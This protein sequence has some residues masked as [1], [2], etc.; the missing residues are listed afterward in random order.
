MA[1]LPVLI[2]AHVDA[3]TS[4][5]DAR[6]LGIHAVQIFIGDPQGWKKPV[7][8]YDGGPAALREA[9]Q[10]ARITAYVHAP[11]VINVASTNNRIRI[12]S[13]KLL[14]QTLHAAAEIGAAGVIVHGGHVTAEDDPGQG[15]ENWFKAVG[16]AE[17]EVPMLVENTAGGSHAMARTLPQLEQLWEAISAAENGERVGFCLD[18][19]HAFAAGL[20]LAT[21]VDDVRAA[22]GRIDLLHL[23][24]SRGDAGSGQDRHAG[25]GQGQIDPEQIVQVI[26]AAG[27]PVILETPGGTEERTADIAWLRDRLRPR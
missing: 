22:T 7:V 12:P 26:R 27:V 15:Y 20:D 3:S 5:D 19:C 1:D 4:V 24:D 9:L 25:L 10:E 18:T 16:G 17:L 6:A 13:R 2:G 23:N 14:N 11:Y 21:V 8:S